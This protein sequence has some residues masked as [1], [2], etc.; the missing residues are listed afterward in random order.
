MTTMN[1]RIAW[2]RRL[3]GAALITVIS[4]LACSGDTAGDF[5]IIDGW[6]PVG[7][8]RVYDADNLW[9]YINGAAELF[10]AYDVQ[11][12]RTADLSSGDLVVTVDLY[13]M[14]EPLN[15][16][17][18]FSRERTG[19]RTAVSG[20]TDATVSPPYLALLLKGSTYAKINVLEGELTQQSAGALLEA[21]AA[22]LPGDTALPVELDRLPREGRIA[23]TEGFQ[24]E[25]YLGLTELTNCVYAE[26][27]DG[28][29]AWQ[30]FVAL[31]GWEG[32][33]ERWDRLEHGGEEVLYTE[34]P[35]R[36]F[37]G[38][39]RTAD[40][41]LGVAGVADRESLLTRLNAFGR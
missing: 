15:A 21:L 28:G 39:R 40:G 37:A 32:L 35:Y 9:E 23:G 6:T 17:G 38:V 16:F 10:V 31:S 18:V 19:Q 1:R 24:R 12:C 11:A 22:Q 14:G 36:G 3:A 4:G 25:G 20:A 7:E 41:V 33:A 30:G 13:D 5:P 8:V 2:A 34:I 29:E 26:Y 27:A